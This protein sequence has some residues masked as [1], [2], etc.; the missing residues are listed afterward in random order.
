MVNFVKFSLVFV[1]CLFTLVGCFSTGPLRHLSSDVCLLFPEQTTKRD[2]VRQLGTP[3]LMREAADSETWFYYQV[4]KS[5]LAGLPWLG[6]TIG[7]QTYEVVTV[8]FTGVEVRACVFRSMSKQEFQG[9]GITAGDG[10]DAE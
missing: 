9:L 5:F 6:D 4:D 3:D 7:T 2:V 1:V 8:T 10:A